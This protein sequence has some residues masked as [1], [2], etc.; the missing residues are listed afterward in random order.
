L[1]TARADAGAADPP[2]PVRHVIVGGCPAAVIDRQGLARRMVADCLAARGD[3]AAEPRLVFASNGHGLSLAVTDRAYREA[4]FQADIVCA[5]GGAI[6]AASRLLAPHAIPERAATTDFVHDAAAAAAGAGLSFYLLGGT[7]AVNEAAAGKLAARHPGLRIAGRSQ[8]YFTEADEP[9][10][11]TA[12]AE[13]GADVVWVGL[14]RPKEQ[15]FSVRNRHRLRAGWIV[16]CG[17]CFNF[18][19][20]DYRRAPRWM[21]EHGLEW[22]HRM[23]TGPRSLIWRYLTTNPHALYLLATRTRGEWPGPGAR[24]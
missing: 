5:D 24:R 8:G 2:E 21:R 12:I 4:L 6:V 17:G 10:V 15:L 19:S 23:A 20:G 1:S 18:L 11:C 3:P 22:L 7:E 9:A 13:S 14:G 16:T